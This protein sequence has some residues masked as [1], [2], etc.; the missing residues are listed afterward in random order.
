MGQKHAN[1]VDLVTS[2]PTSIYLQRFVSIQQRTSLSKFEVMYSLL[3]IRLLND[4]PLLF[5]KGRSVFGFVPFLLSAWVSV[6]PRQFVCQSGRVHFSWGFFFV[7][8]L[9][10]S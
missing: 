5:S 9:D 8:F 3:F 2:F 4:S 6:P 1:L 7:S 10:R